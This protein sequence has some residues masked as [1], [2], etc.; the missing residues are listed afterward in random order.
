M[1]INEALDAIQTLVHCQGI[2]REIEALETIRATLAVVQNS[3]HNSAMDAIAI[4]QER[5][6]GDYEKLSDF[7]NISLVVDTL[8]KLQQPPCCSASINLSKDNP[9][10]KYCPYCGR[11]LDADPASCRS[12]KKQNDKEDAPCS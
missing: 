1:E 9:L 8:A 11:R 12:T 2:S 5:F 4:L 6:G 10:V 3:S 7:D